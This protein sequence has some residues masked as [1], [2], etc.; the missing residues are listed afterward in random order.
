MSIVCVDE[1]YQIRRAARKFS[2]EMMINFWK[3]KAC[4]LKRLFLR[5]PHRD[6]LIYHKLAITPPGQGSLILFIVQVKIAAAIVHQYISNAIIHNGEFEFVGLYRA[7][8]L[9][10]KTS[11]YQLA[12]IG[13]KNIALFYQVVQ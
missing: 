6:D 3:E 5:W 8:G 2:Y 13:L 10:T 12:F 7:D 11:L 4:P 9:R 1:I